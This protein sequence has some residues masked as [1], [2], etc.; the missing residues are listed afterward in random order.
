MTVIKTQ[1]LTGYIKMKL[2]SRIKELEQEP[3][4]LDPGIAVLLIANM[5]LHNQW[6]PSSVFNS[7]S[8]LS[9]LKCST[10]IK[11]NSDNIS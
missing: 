5:H 6:I 4:R 3:R 11:P 2:Q 10:T 7:V 1:N 9:F 8:R